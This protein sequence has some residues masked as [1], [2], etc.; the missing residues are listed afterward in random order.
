M[1]QYLAEEEK[2][3][4]FVGPKLIQ[5]SAKIAI[6]KLPGG[7]TNQDAEALAREVYDGHEAFDGEPTSAQWMADRIVRLV[8]LK[9][10]RNV[11]LKEKLYA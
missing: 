3:G 11:P 6:K 8:I 4:R 2:A 5:E 9:K 1:A 7:Y 10:K